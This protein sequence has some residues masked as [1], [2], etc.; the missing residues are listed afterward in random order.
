[1]H[2][3]L[4]A[5]AV[6][7]LIVAVVLFELYGWAVIVWPAI[8]L[9]V[10]LALYLALRYQRGLRGR[11]VRQALALR[12]EIARLEAEQGVP[13]L[14]DGACKECGQLLIAG[15]RYCSYCKAPTE[16]KAQVCDICG[17]RNAHNAAW[18]G[19]C[20]AALPEEDEV[21]AGVPGA[22]RGLPSSLIRD[23]LEWPPYR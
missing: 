11:K 9:G 14:T 3:H 23:I 7:L 18:C 16:R 21:A 8:M 10:V 4:S 19:A 6:I 5:A 22:Q 12:R 1:M 20:G 15:A 13:L 17:T 2:V